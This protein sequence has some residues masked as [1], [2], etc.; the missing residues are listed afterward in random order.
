MPKDNVTQLTAAQRVAK[1]LEGQRKAAARADA[2]RRRAGKQ[3][4]IAALQQKEITPAEY[5]ELVGET[6]AE[7][8]REAY[9]HELFCARERLNSRVLGGFLS[10]EDY[11]SITGKPYDEEEF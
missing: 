6:Y 8:L 4:A 9:E 11:E 7:T 5:Q 1:A 3:P 10:P 2:D